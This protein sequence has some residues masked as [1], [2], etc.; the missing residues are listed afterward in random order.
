M[1]NLAVTKPSP[2]NIKR[3]SKG[4]K[5]DIKKHNFVQQSQN[6][7]KEFISAMFNM[8]LFDKISSTEIQQQKILIENSELYET[9]FS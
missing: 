6:D 3:E 2:F 7:Q 5:E 1:D 9:F 8:L 4:S